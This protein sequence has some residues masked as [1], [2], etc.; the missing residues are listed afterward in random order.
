MYLATGSL[1]AI[2]LM[3]WGPHNRKLCPKAAV[4]EVDADTMVTGRM[5]PHAGM[6]VGVSIRSRRCILCRHIGFFRWLRG[7]W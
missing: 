2:W 7:I 4:D 3:S 1:Q 6:P 5:D